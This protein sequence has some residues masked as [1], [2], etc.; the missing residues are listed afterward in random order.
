MAH[1]AALRIAEIVRP[2][3]VAAVVFSAAFL[4]V[5]ASNS[6]A[7]KCD[8]DDSCTEDTVVLGN[9]GAILGSSYEVFAAGA[10]KNTKA[11][12]E[13]KGNQTGLA[14]PSGVAITPDAQTIA[15]ANQL[16]GNVLVFG[17]GATGNSAPSARIGGPTTGLEN[18]AGVAFLPGNDIAVASTLGAVVDPGGGP[19]PT[20][21][22]DPAVVGFSL[23]VISEFA[24]G[25][26]GD[27]TPLNNSP[28]NGGTR[29]ATIGGCATFLLGP[30]GLASEP[31]GKLWAANSFGGFITSYAAGASGDAFP[32]NIIAGAI[33]PAFVAVGAAGTEIYVTDL[34]DNSV[35]IFDATTFGGKLLGVISG[36]R[37][38]FNSPMG[39]D[40]VGDDLYVANN[41][42]NNFVMFDDDAGELDLGGNI[43]PNVIVRGKHTN[44]NLPTG[45]AVPHP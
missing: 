11:T 30:T 17:S 35:K 19:P 6:Y 44:M 9:N 4:A 43:R 3:S 8:K 22:C 1:R 39:I 10:R 16:G 14:S 24:A 18:P 2:L 23:G 42:A 13:V 32:D 21:I 15:I 38:K 5:T 45:L 29:N 40:F 28:V 20:G 41:E 7:A 36:K 12:H 33:A 34:G 26:N 37:T 27:V 25:S 31:S